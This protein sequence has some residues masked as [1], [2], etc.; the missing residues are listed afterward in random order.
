[1]KL[2]NSNDLYRKLANLK[3]LQ[4]K[5][6]SEKAFFPGATWLAN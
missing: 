4:T 2:A 5:L 3:Y 1:M 6:R